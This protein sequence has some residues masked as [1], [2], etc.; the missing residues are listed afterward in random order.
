MCSVVRDDPIHYNVFKADFLVRVIVSTVCVQHIVR[1][2]YVFGCRVRGIS[3]E[4]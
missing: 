3:F 2:L 1:F 4:G